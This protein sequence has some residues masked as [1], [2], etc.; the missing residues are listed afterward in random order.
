MELLL[1][2]VWL[3]LAAAAV[4]GFVRSGGKGSPERIPYTKS[5]LALGCTLVLLFPFVSASDDLHPT[6]AI[7]EDSSKRVQ[8]GLTPATHPQSLPAFAMLLSLLSILVLFGPMFRRPLHSDMLS[9]QALD[10]QTLAAAGRA[11]PLGF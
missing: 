4:L 1:N 9:A 7:F 2:L 10:G 6:Q 5:L 8:Q 3:V 11:P